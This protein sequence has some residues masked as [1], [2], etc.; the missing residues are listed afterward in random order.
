MAKSSVTEVI[1]LFLSVFDKVLDRMPNYSQ[2]KKKQYY[3][4]KK[5]YLDEIKSE[6]RS[7]TAVDVYFGD[8]ILFI[9]CFGAELP[10]QKISD[11]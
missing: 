5:A 11:V 9:E 7:D 1:T 2:R 6:N 3:K 8:L 10:K 4:L